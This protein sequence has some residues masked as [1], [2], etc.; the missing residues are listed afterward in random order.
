MLCGDLKGKETQKRED[1]CVHVADSLCCTAETETAL[2]SN[3][4]LFKKGL[5]GD[6]KEALMWPKKQKYY[7]M[8]K[9]RVMKRPKDSAREITG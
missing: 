5:E 4:T 2:Y 7:V 6:T 1:P 9:K 3:C 8:P